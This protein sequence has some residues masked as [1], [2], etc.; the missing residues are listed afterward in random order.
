MMN[1]CPVI[2]DERAEIDLAPWAANT[3]N[4]RANER[5]HDRLS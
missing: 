5:A 1:I 4:R 2:S 3:F